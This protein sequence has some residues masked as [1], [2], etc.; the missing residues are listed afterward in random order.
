M[1]RFMRNK[2]CFMLLLFA[3]VTTV[4]PSAFAGTGAT[5][6]AWEGPL[7]TI[8]KSLSGPVAFVIC[9]VGIVTAF[10][11]VMFGGEMNE[12]AKKALYVVAAGAVMVGAVP[13]ASTLF[14]ISGAL[15]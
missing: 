10:S 4:A 9:I 14:G 12:L 2:I 3:V 15:V 8:Q 5:G 7:Q 13:F 6:L 11:V 1:G